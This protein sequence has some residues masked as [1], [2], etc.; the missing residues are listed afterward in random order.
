MTASLVVNGAGIIGA[1]AIFA[2]SIAAA[3]RAAV[4]LDLVARPNPIVRSHRAPVPYLGGAGLIAAY[5]A[6]L[7]GSWALE[8]ALPARDVLGR[9]AGALG[10]AAL[11]TWDDARP[12]GPWFKLVVQSAL[13]AAYLLVAG[14]PPGPGFM[15]KLLVLVTLVNAYNIIDVMDGLLCVLAGLAVLGLLVLRSPASVSLTPELTLMLVGLGVL[16]FFN[17]PPARIY[18]G[19][20]GSLPLGFLVA[21]WGL[22]AAG[23]AVTVPSLAIVGLWGVPLLELALVIPARLA[24]GRSPLRGSPDHFALR[25]QD[26]LGWNKWRV[27]DAASIVGAGFA[28]APWVSTRLGA[29]ASAIYAFACVL[30]AATTWRALWRIPPHP[31]SHDDAPAGAAALH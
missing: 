18:A 15:L 14:T 19:D 11:G 28:A 7:A 22:A 4:T 3:R 24:K 9:S 16:F 5:L 27:L 12:L 1:A 17:R 2:A 20:A 6:L 23:D 10:F 31:R 21:A 29:P 13:C 26:A 30:V 25:L 8:G